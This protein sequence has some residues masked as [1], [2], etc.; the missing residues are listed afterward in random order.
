[1]GLRQTVGITVGRQKCPR[2]YFW[3]KVTPVASKWL[4]LRDHL[5]AAPGVGFI[6]AGRIGRNLRPER[7]SPGSFGSP[8]ATKLSR[9]RRSAASPVRLQPLF[10]PALDV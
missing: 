7:F 5:S 2:L 10:H 3:D 4:I 8:R 6:K 9:S 1:M